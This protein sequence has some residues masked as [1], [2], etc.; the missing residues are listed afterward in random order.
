MTIT[1]VAV[2]YDDS[3][4]PETTGGYCFRALQKLVSVAH[5]RPE[6]V[7]RVDPASW[8]LF[9]RVDDGLP[10]LLP[11]TYRPLAWWAIDT[12]LEFDRCLDQ[13]R[14]ADLTFAAQR[15]GAEALAAAGVAHAAWLPLACD[16]EVHR[17]HPVPKAY[18][19]SFV[20]H[21]FPGERAGLLAALRARFPTHF[22][23]RAY[24]DEMARVY[25]AS[26]TT[27]NRSVRDD[28]NMRVFEAAAC[29]SLLLTNDLAGG[30]QHELFRDGVHLATYRDAGELLDKLAY[31]LSHADARGRVEDAGR[32][33]AVERHTY[34][35]RM[36]RVLERASAL[37]LR[38]AVAGPARPAPAVD[39]GYFEHARPEILEMIPSEARE[40]LDIGC[41][42]GRLGEALKGRQPARVTGIERNPGAAEAAR[43]RLDRVLEVDAEALQVGQ[44]LPATFDIVVCGDIL[45]HLRDPLATLKTLGT[46]LKPEGSL[47]ASL[48]NVQHHSVVR[49]LLSGD[50]SY[51]PAGLLDQTHLRFFTR[52][53][54]E[55]L[56]FR[57][58]FDWQGVAAIPGAGYAEW[59]AAGKPGEVEVGGLQIG[60]LQRDEAEAFFAYQW[61]VAARPVLDP[62]F[63]TTSVIFLAH[64]EIAHTRACI[65]SIR[66][67]TDE[68][69]EMV[70]VDNGS[71][72]GTA[73]YFR[74]LARFDPR[75][76]LI[77]NPTNRGYPAAV[78]QGMH[79][80]TGDQLLL[81]NNDTIVTTGWLRRMLRAL[82]GDRTIGLV[83]PCSN[84]VSGIQQ[85]DAVYDDPASLDRFAWEFAKAREGLVE[86]ADRLVGFCLLIRRPVVDAIGL[87]DEGFGIGNFEDDDYCLRA[88]RAGFRTVIARDSFVHHVG[89]VTFRGTG[90]DYTE[91]MRTNQD[92]FR[93]KWG[94]PALRSDEH[95]LHP[96]TGETTPTHPAL[97]PAADPDLTQRNPPSF[98]LIPAMG[99]GLLLQ[100]TAVCVSGCLIV[101]DNEQTIRACLESLRPWVDE[102]VVVDTG[103][104]DQTPAIA[105]DCGARVFHFPWVDDFSA[106]RNESVRH[107][108]GKWVFWMDSD[109]VI[110]AT[111]G[112][113]VR[114]LADRDPD[115]LV[116]GYVIRVH[117]PGPDPGG[118]NDLTVVDHVKL[119]RN[120]PDLRFEGRIHEQILPA[121]RRAGGEVA[122]TDAFVLHAGYDHTP[123]GQERKKVR[124]LRILHRELA[125]R[126]DHPFTLFN[127]GMT[128]A[129]VGEHPTAIEFLRQ[130]LRHSE[131]GESHRR[132]AYALIAFCESRLERIL[133]A[134]QV[135]QEGL[136]EF[137]GDLELRFRRGLLLQESGRLEEA[138]AA[139]EDILDNPGER[140][141]ASVDR[142]IG[143]FKARQNL[144]AVHAARGDW[145]RAEREWRHVT[146]EAPTYP[147]GWRGLGESLVR[148]KKYPEAADLVTRLTAEPGLA[149]EGVLLT[150]RIATDRG[151]VAEA[152]GLLRTASKETGDLEPLQDLCRLLFEHYGA[153]AAEPMLRDL[154]LRSPRDAAAFHNLGTALAR[155]GKSADA[156]AAY[157]KS[158]ELRPKSGDTWARLGDVLC[159]AGRPTDAE[160]A[161]GEARRLGARN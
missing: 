144:A 57:A 118:H 77:L 93:Q 138:V 72:D 16:P 132:K 119:F 10:Y 27:F 97:P 37:P 83:G 67:R 23:G 49:G 108:R 11:E 70:L 26:R 103:S 137:P 7:D 149:L 30:G 8:D 54:V 24:F 91:L 101:R 48:P 38:V 29:G 55:K 92:R 104:K 15:P 33:R 61:R 52:R 157:R 105:K 98:T 66:F 56:L 4:R 14:R 131:P 95:G 146:D 102:L 74:S 142:G 115:P 141:F 117:C 12:H 134:H 89:Q 62:R 121:I 35:H 39:P 124:D 110:D 75:V 58:G 153:E 152:V 86:E 135:C 40:I 21:E 128:Y 158:V 18:D 22:V 140:Y 120:R 45:E 63:G 113:I 25:S 65:E 46:W 78:N 82:H 69:I 73:E 51:E 122:W 50:W 160:Q 13:A 59:D 94:R 64:N 47:V 32:L 109:D 125:E 68:P 151:E 147:T 41:G 107:A 156:V 9:V 85:V 145:A 84:R 43:H 123:E 139:Y 60:E 81:L 44:F 36:A 155:L 3:R 42:A 129:D 130:C 34:R 87:L 161:W 1:R 20:G 80:A 154:T 2:V 99:G 6:Q 127:L 90:V 53:E 5:V 71:T 116:L 88:Q 31:Y 106:A 79:E 150:A 143:G 19:F 17:P 133:E 126:P 159:D 96:G 28:V 76:K 136:T 100:P 111:N 114:D 148:Q 112:R